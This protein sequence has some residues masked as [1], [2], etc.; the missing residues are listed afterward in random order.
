MDNSNKLAVFF[1]LDDTL[2]DHLVP[3]REAVRE[4]LAPDE[5]EA[6]TMRSYFI[7]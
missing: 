6:W 4:V 3:F 5:D 2:Y 1:D 7:K